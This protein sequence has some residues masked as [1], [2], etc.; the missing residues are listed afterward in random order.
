MT[1]PLALFKAGFAAEL[2]RQGYTR[3]SVEHQLRLMAHLSRWLA[4][5]GL[6]PKDFTPNVAEQFLQ[7]RRAGPYS[8]HLS[9]Q[10]LAAARAPAGAARR[11][12]TTTSPAPAAG[13]EAELLCRYRRFLTLERG[14]QRSSLRAYVNAV[15]PFLA[16][17]ASPGGLDLAGLDA[18]QVIAFVVAHC[19]GLPRGSAKLAGCLSN[20]ERHGRAVPGIGASCQRIPGGAIDE[21]SLTCTRL[22]LPEPAS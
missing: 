16:R 12:A 18:A 11:A 7:A 22:D 10:G 9:T 13:S 17:Q 19:P 4:A 21:R 5:E 3:N 6:E 20:G 8:I 1:G 15:R 14:F 2:S